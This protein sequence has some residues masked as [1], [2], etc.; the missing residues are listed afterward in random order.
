M[1][2]LGA[3]SLENNLRKYPKNMGGS[4]AQCPAQL[5]GKAILTG[6]DYQWFDL[7]SDCKPG[8]RLFIAYQI[9]SI[10]SIVYRSLT[11]LELG[12]CDIYSRKK[13]KTQTTK[14]IQ[15]CLQLK[16]SEIPHC[17]PITAKP[18]YE[19]L[20]TAEER[21]AICSN[22]QRR[23]IGL[24]YIRIRCRC[25]KLHL[26]YIMKKMCLIAEDTIQNDCE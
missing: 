5:Q 10:Y 8:R 11:I 17:L 6:N 21:W 9:G 12:I 16:G 14:A 19:K 22:S 4:S 26:V 24:W 23:G 7:F 15:Y 18:D 3:I 25:L 13:T 20:A 1:R 2:I